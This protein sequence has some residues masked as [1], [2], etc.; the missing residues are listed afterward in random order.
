MILTIIGAETQ[1]SD[2]PKDDELLLLKQP[3]VVEPLADLAETRNSDDP[4]DVFAEINDILF[5]SPSASINSINDIINLPTSD[6]DHQ[7]TVMAPKAITP[8]SHVVKNHPSRHIIGDIISMTARKK[9][10]ARLC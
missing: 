3:T 10:K 6:I 7:N 4:K 5:A 2:D 9:G 8:S 1:N